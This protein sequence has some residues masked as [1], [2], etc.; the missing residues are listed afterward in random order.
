MPEVPVG[1]RTRSAVLATR[2]TTTTATTTTTTSTA[3]LSSAVPVEVSTP[4]IS[5][6]TT[7]A[8]PVSASARKMRSSL[9]P[10][11][12]D[13]RKSWSG[14]RVVDI[15]L[16]LKSIEANCVCK[17]CFQSVAI[18]E[19][20]QCGFSSKFTLSCSHCELSETFRNSEMITKHV[21]EV[22]RR[23]VYAFKSLGL[24]YS[25]YKEFCALMDFPTP[26]ASTTFDRGVDE[27]NEAST[28]VA[29]ESMK[30]AA[31]EE[32]EAAGK[33]NITVSGDGTW[34]K[35]GFSSL[36][37]VVTLIGLLTGKVIDFLVLSLVCKICDAYKGEKKGP[38][39]EEWLEEHSS[40][41]TKNH[42][43]SSGKMEVDGM[44]QLFKRSVKERGVIYEDY[45]GD[46]DSKTYKAITESNPYKKEK[47]LVKKRECTAHVQKRMGT[48]L[49]NL[50]K[51][52]S[53]KKLSDGK[54]ISGK[55]RLTDKVIDQ[56]AGYYGKAIRSS[57]TLEQMKKAVWAIF[58]HMSSTDA[59]PSHQNCPKGADSWCKYQQA[60]AAKKAKKFKHKQGV[61]V[62]CMVACKKVFEDLTAEDLLSRCLGGY[63]QNPNESVN[64]S[65]WLLC[66]KVKFF[67]KKTVD[68]AAAEGVL[69][70]NDGCRAKVKVLRRM[71]IQPGSSC[72]NWSISEDNARVVQA[73][74]RAKAATKEARMARLKARMAAQQNSQDDS[75]VP[76]GH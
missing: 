4:S 38:D 60:V 18:R 34:Q 53:K 49:R 2:T 37:G 55:G 8:S 11:V 42:E 3:Q 19:T 33:T 6:A 67:G 59:K 17:R 25:N 44:V 9:N 47:I 57:N 63:T 61:P 10:E 36:F 13:T 1:R 32:A 54:V 68:I 16:F 74:F 46:G 48:R 40:N 62:A 72:I 14:F 30:Q 45:I 21:A 58:Y 39:Y 73:Q 15:D 5:G 51:E 64:N 43:G 50:K 70:F 65:I 24:G 20:N 41:C 28:Q 71:G 22:N 35:R 27:I 12:D 66:P 7:T 26:V 23:S 31:V 69:Q 29:E 52:L 76:G 56:I 75:Y